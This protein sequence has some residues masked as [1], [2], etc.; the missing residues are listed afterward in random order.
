MGINASLVLS[1]EFVI[2]S[3]YFFLIGFIVSNYSISGYLH[4]ELLD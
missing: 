3:N 2:V 4:V 1:K